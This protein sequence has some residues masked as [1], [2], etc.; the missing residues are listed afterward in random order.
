D[1]ETGYKKLD[2]SKA[3]KTLIRV[4]ADIYNATFLKII[5]G[6]TYNI[7]DIIPK[8]KTGT[9]IETLSSAVID[10]DKTRDGI[11][12]L[13]EWKA[14]FDFLDSF[15]DKN[16]V[17]IPKIPAKYGKKL[18]RIIAEPSLNPVNLVRNGTWVTWTAVGVLAFCLCIV[19]GLLGFVRKKLNQYRR[20]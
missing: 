7:L 19:L 20:L 14:P 3:N 17:G 5:G 1:E 4:T 2:F 8:D 11:Q 15:E 18:G 13:K 12:E 9:P 16:E 6:Y 10:G